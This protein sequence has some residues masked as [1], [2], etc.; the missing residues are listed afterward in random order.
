MINS[1]LSRKGIKFCTFNISNLYNALPLIDPNTSKSTS[2]TFLKNSLM[3]T[4]SCSM[5]TTI[6]STLKFGMVNLNQASWLKNYSPNVLP[7]RATTNAN[8]LL[9]YGTT[10][11]GPTCSHSLLMTLA[12]NTC[13]RNMLSIFATPSKKTM[14]SRKIGKV[15]STQASTLIGTTPNAPAILLWK[16]TSILSSPSTIARGPKDQSYYHTRPPKFYMVQK[17]STP[18]TQIP[19][20]LSMKQVSNESNTL[21]APS[22]TMPA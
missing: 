2:P 16:T 17:F 22:Y 14:T 7:K 6:G 5:Y 18:M 3:S 10:N 19:H 4:I 8:A 21:S 1:M 13:A 15:T 11:G 20:H 9:D 12:L